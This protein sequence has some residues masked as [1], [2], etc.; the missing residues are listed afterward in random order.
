MSQPP[1][2]NLAEYSSE[3]ERANTFTHA[4][5]AL[6]TIIA[7]P[8]LFL[9]A[10]GVGSLQ[11][12]GLILFGL[13]MLFVYLSSTFYHAATNLRL[14][15]LLQRTDH[16]S[17]Y[18]LIAGT[19][20]PFV[21]LYLNHRWGY[22]YLTI[23]WTMAFVGMLYKIF[24][25][26]RFPRLSV[27]YYLVLG[28]MAVFILKPLMEQ[29]PSMALFWVI[30]GGVSYT[31]GTFFYVKEDIR[32]SHAIWHVFVIGGSVGHYLALWEAVTSV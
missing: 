19:H 20:T 29:M 13:S 10:Q 31:L 27:A 12:F 28:W 22:I 32:Y 8:F 18:F 4:I 11:L 26:G 21:L 9:A 15:W 23:L 2:E 1:K 25:F 7:M 24:Y 6:L 30:A 16:I 17:I 5:G 14:K 3:E